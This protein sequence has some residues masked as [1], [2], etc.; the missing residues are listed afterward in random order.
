MTT[1]ELEPGALARLVAFLYART[2][3][4]AISPEKLLAELATCCGLA[5]T[6]PKAP[7][8]KISA[9]PWHKLSDVRYA[10]LHAGKMQVAHI[11]CRHR[12][13]WEN[14]LNREGRGGG[15][16]EGDYWAFSVVDLV[17]ELARNLAGH[18]SQK[19][20]R[21]SRYDDCL[22]ALKAKADKEETPQVEEEVPKPKA[23]RKSK[24]KKGD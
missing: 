4:H 17:D 19:L 8:A 14:M 7:P 24:G 20:G 15:M 22:A 23:K 13:A 3:S 1:T 12:D 11:A 16:S 2:S 5:Y 9:K 21:G 6:A 10:K 18:A